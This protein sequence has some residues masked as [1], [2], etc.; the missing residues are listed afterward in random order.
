MF[1]RNGLICKVLQKVLLGEIFCFF[2][3]LE[4]RAAVD[5]RAWRQVLLRTIERREETEL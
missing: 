1:I 5:A 3:C 4:A 2:S